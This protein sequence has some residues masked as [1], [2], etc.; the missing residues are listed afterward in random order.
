[1][2]EKNE[3]RHV[4]CEVSYVNASKSTQHWIRLITL[5]C[6]EV[7]VTSYLTNNNCEGGDFYALRDDRNCSVEEP[8]GLCK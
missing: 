6:Y 2:H 4:I 3:K 7:G 5:R 1:M 8:N